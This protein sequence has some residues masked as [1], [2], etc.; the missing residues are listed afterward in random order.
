MFLSGVLEG[1]LL[2]GSPV[3][4]RV[5][6]VCCGHRGF[7]LWLL[8]NDEVEPRAQVGLLTTRGSV[9][10]RADWPSRRRKC[11]SNTT[12]SPEAKS[13]EQTFSCGTWASQSALWVVTSTWWAWFW[14]KRAQ[15]HECHRLFLAMS[16]D[17]V[18]SAPEVER[19]PTPCGDNRNC[20][21]R[22]AA[23]CKPAGPAPCYFENKG[24]W[25]CK[26]QHL[27]MSVPSIQSIK[28]L[29]LGFKKNCFERKV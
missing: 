9:R 1:I 11:V 25:F 15:D 8:E 23:A 17:L 3:S 18:S 14:Y 19:F 7:D 4:C 24:N 26:A 5:Q 29:F 13:W 20:G 10:M 21:R 12:S 28:R 22:K 27:V 16:L 2:R 6:H